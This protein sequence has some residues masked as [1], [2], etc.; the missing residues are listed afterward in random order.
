MRR[1]TRQSASNYTRV[2][3]VSAEGG[4]TLHFFWK[5]KEHW[6][7]RVSDIRSA[8]ESLLKLPAADRCSPFI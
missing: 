2:I 8:C 7:G 6:N 1:V 5:G 4:R 3:P